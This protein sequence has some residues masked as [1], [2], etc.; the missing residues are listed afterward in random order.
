MLRGVIPKSGGVAEYDSGCII[1]RSQLDEAFPSQFYGGTLDSPSE[2]ETVL[3][4]SVASIGSVSYQ[5]VTNT[6]RNTIMASSPFVLPMHIPS[7]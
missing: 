6:K 5:Q 1:H 3:R 2:H 7:E 4:F